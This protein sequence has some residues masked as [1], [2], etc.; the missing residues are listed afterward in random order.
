MPVLVRNN[1]GGPTCYTH[2]ASGTQLEWAGRGDPDGNDI[3]EVEDDLLKTS[4]MSRVMRK[5][6]LSRVDDATGQQALRRQT[7]SHVERTKADHEA[8]VSTIDGSAE[9]P[10]AQVQIDEKGNVTDT[11]PAPTSGPAVTTTDGSGDPV[12]FTS[13]GQLDD[14]GQEILTEA[15]VIIDQPGSALPIQT[16]L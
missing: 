3:Q 11:L 9:L 6:I 8:I 15:Q 1:E 10:V 13:T 14:E 12:A 4:D 5:G 7:E 2:K 16:P